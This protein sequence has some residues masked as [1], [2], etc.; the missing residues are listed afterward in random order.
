[1]TW[2]EGVDDSPRLVVVNQLSDAEEFQLLLNDRRSF[3]RLAAC[4]IS[5]S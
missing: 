1:M 4:A 2:G 3:E 5:C